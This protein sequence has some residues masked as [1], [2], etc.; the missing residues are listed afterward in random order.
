MIHVYPVPLIVQAGLI[1]SSIFLLVLIGN[2]C[3]CF[4]NLYIKYNIFKL[5]KS[6]TLAMV[7]TRE[8]ILDVNTDKTLRRETS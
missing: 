1:E 8:I 4:K 5:C 7:G 2:F 3:F 6:H